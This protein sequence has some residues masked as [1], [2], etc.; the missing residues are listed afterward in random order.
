MNTPIANQS[1]LPVWRRRTTWLALIPALGVLCLAALPP[2]PSDQANMVSSE[3]R[4][5]G[6][7]LSLVK[8]PDGTS[9]HSPMSF[10]AGG[11]MI[12][13]DP[14]VF[15]SGPMTTAYH[16]TWTKTGRREFV[17]TMVGFSYRYADPSEAEWYPVE[18]LYKI[19]IKETDTILE[20]GDTYEGEGTVEW[21]HPDGTL[22]VAYP[23][24]THADRIRAE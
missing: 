17:F 22:L 1:S 19:V 3:A 11:A 16:G 20:D 7:W 24:P 10:C 2:A 6:S 21:Y 15:P 8:F 18:G 23:V 12:V 5:E 13:S 9:I 4:L 14:M